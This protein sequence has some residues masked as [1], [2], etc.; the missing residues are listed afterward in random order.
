INI[1]NDLIINNPKDIEFIRSQFYNKLEIFRFS[2][3]LGKFVGYTEY[4]VKQAEYFNKDT[5]YIAGL[6]ADKERYCLNNVGNDYRNMLTKS[7]DKCN[8]LVSFPPSSFS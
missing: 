1:I 5:S 6:K 7:G 3:S 4:G 8:N 2:S